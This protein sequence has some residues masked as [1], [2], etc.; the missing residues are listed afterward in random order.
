VLQAIGHAILVRYDDATATRVT[1]DEQ[2]NAHQANAP[3]SIANQSESKSQT[4]NTTIFIKS[5]ETKWSYQFCC[6]SLLS[7]SLLILK[8]ADDQ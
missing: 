2:L 6:R 5:K 3:Q 8:L 4:I 7:P 1:S